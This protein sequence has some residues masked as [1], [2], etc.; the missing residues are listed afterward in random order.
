MAGGRRPDDAAL[1]GG[2]YYLPTILA[3]APNTARICREEIFGPVLVVLPFEDEADVVVQAND[4]D[5][6]LACGIW[7]R[8]FPKAW[9]VGRAVTT[10]TVWINMYKQFSIATP[11][12]GEKDSGM[13]REKGR[14]GLRAYQAQK[15]IYTDL[16][17][18][19]H[20]WA[21]DLFA[22]V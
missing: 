19:P 6:G 20:P 17:N 18:R 21:A 2:A 8:A 14:E 3:D 10:G 11:F 13:A 4:N 1:A 7:T 12:G 15:A 5:Y 22:G 16:T 9:R